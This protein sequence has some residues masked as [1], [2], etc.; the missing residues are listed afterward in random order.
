MSGGEDPV[1][2]VVAEVG[3]V[4]DRHVRR[5]LAWAAEEWI[6]KPEHRRDEVFGA[7]SDDRVE[8]YNAGVESLS[9]AYAVWREAFAYGR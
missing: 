6:V 2:D 7:M 9:D 8:G 4:F 5:F 3:E 1:D